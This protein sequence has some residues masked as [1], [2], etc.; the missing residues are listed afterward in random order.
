MTPQEAL[1]R[2][3]GELALDLPAGGSAQL[4]RYIALLEKW[5]RTYNLTAIRD[6]PFARLARRGSASAGAGR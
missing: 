3:L 6:P 5:N 4:M 2:G 1:D